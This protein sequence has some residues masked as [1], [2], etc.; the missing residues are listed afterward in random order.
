MLP[1][2]VSHAN[3]NKSVNLITILRVN[4]LEWPYILILNELS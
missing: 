2:T 1:G 4:V 3:K